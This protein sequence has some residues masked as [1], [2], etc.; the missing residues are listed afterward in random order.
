MPQSFEMWD[1]RFKRAVP[2]SICR[3]LGGLGPSQS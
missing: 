2:Q 3:A 1:F